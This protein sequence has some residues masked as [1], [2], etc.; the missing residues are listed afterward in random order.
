MTRDVLP[1]TWV[2]LRLQDV[3]EERDD[4]CGQSSFPVLSITKSR[5][6][7]LAGER[8]ARALHSKDVRRYRLS[9]RDDFVVDPMLLWDGQIARQRVVDAGIVSPDYR[10]YSVRNGVEPAYLEYVLRSSE[11]RDRYRAGARGALGAPTSGAGAL[12]APTSL[13]FPFAFRP[14]LSSGG[15]PPSSRL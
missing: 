8:F 6:M 2:R 5:G 9:R 14:L 11:M 7:V 1:H 10:V 15:S 12:H 13:T 3:L 4:R